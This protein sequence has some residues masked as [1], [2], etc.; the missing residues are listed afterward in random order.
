MGGLQRGNDAFGAGE[1]SGGIESSL[2]GDGGI[3]GAALIG[4]PGM[5]GADGGVVEAGGDGMRCGDLAVFILQDVSVSPL[6][7]AGARSCKS[8][9]RG[10]A[11]G[12]F[13]E[14]TAAAAGFN[15][16]HFHVRVGQKLIKKADG[17]RTAADAC[18]KI[19]RQT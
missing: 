11:R 2:I 3:F 16:D 18:K 13:A 7:N 5:L 10:E 8:L 9:M 1:K 17:I 6:E 19:R 12:V 14:L 15:A 4:E